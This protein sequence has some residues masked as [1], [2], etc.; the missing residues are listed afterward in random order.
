MQKPPAMWPWAHAAVE[1][2]LYTLYC[3]FR[4]A[5]TPSGPAVIA[6]GFG[7]QFPDLVDKIGSWYL[8][9][10][11]AGRSFA[12]SLLVAMPI[13]LLIRWYTRYRSTP[14]LGI[15][16]GI[17]YVSHTLADGLNSFLLLEWQY[18]SYLAWPLLA[19]PEYD[20]DKSLLAHL[21][22]LEATPFFAFEGVLSVVALLLW[23]HH[24]YPGTETLCVWN[25]VR[26]D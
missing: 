4:G 3:W 11:P 18:L 19:S 2:L 13:I 24:G 23:A 12:H 10:L 7:T 26:S 5:S 6:L 14:E 22:A 17:G 1:Y 20:T 8:Y 21:L 15:A 9:V 25:S 16:F